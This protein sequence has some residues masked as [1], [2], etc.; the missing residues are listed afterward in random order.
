[1]DLKTY[2]IGAL[3]TASQSFHLKVHFSKWRTKQILAKQW[4]HKKMNPEKQVCHETITHNFAWLVPETFRIR[5]VEV[6]EELK[7]E[8]GESLPAIL[9]MQLQI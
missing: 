4:E 5:G 6:R 8:G 9:A 1:M 2:Y 3:Q 7:D